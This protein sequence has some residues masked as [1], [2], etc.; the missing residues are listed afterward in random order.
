VQQLGYEE[1]F[2]RIPHHRNH[3][4]LSVCTRCQKP[5]AH[6]PY[7]HFLEIAERTHKC[8]K[9]TLVKRA[10]RQPESPLSKDFRQ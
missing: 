9:L 7:P 8:I 10:S 5:I 2:V 6:S 3:L 4:T 1:R